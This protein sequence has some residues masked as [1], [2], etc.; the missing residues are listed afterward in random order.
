MNHRIL[1]RRLL[2]EKLTKKHKYLNEN[3]CVLKILNEIDEK[4]IIVEDLYINRTNNN[5]NFR[6]PLSKHNDIYF[7]DDWFNITLQNAYC[8]F[9]KKTINMNLYYNEWCVQR[10]FIGIFPIELYRT[11]NYL[12]IN[13]RFDYGLAST[14]LI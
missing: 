7:F 14:F 6:I 9:Y 8:R 4:E 10:I 1:K 2:I 13:L 3:M 11:E 5:I 12:V